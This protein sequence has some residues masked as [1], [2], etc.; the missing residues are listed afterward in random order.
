MADKQKVLDIL[1]NL[2]QCFDRDN[3]GCISIDEVGP[4]L[5]YLG[6]FPP[7]GELIEVI[8]KQLLDEAQSKE[9]PYPIVEN[10]VIRLVKEREYE[11]DFADTL[12]SAFRILD[13]EKQGFITVERATEVLTAGATG[14]RE[15]ELNEFIRFARHKKDTSRIYYEDYIANLTSLNS[16][17]AI[18]LWNKHGKPN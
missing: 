4:I 18:R 16:R 15:K 17:H 2:F 5:R 7:Q 6:Q 8:H 3:T 14:M 1:R 12:L 9:I 11:P 13:S 10:L